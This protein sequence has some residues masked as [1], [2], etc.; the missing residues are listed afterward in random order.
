MA[1]SEASVKKARAAI[2]QAMADL[3]AVGVTSA[4]LHA[5]AAQAGYKGIEGKAFRTAVKQL[6]DAGIINRTKDEIELTEKGIK[7]EMP[8]AAT[9]PDSSA[10]QAKLLEHILKE[11]GV[12]S[13]E[14]TTKVYNCL[15]D[16]KPHS[17]KDLAKLAGYAGDD[18]KPFRNLMKR[19]LTLKIVEPVAGRGGLVQATDN[20]F[21]FGRPNGGSI[22]TDGKAETT[23]SPTTSGNGGG[24]K[25]KAASAE[26]PETQKN[27]GGGKTTL[28]RKRTKKEDASPTKEDKKK[29]TDGSK[30]TKKA[31]LNAKKVAEVFV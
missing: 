7:E 13:E 15:L 24:K 14:K 2:L 5:V 11:K 20:N 1:A 28:N 4:S 21:P 29:K 23:S 19:M 16:G 27:G 12:P 8:E 22:A 17:K 10:M 6:R 9:V 31:Q 30:E 3:Y 18:S 26:S 25:R